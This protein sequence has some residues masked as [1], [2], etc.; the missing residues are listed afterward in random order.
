VDYFDLLAHLFEINYL[1]PI[2]DWCEENGV[3]AGGHLLLEHDPRRFMEGGCGHPM[4]SFRHFHIP[5]IDSIFRES[6]PYER[7]HHFPKYV[8]SVARQTGRPCSCMPFGAS[9][10]AVTPAIF[11]WTVD[12]QLVRGVQLFLPWGY[13]PNPDIHYQWSR[14]VFGHFGPLWKY[15]DIAYGYTARLSY[16]LSLGAPDCR[17]ALYFDMRSIWAGEPWRTRAIDA[18]EAIAKA[19]LESQHDFDF[20]DDDG[21][22]SATLEPGGGLRVGEMVYQTL[23]VPENEWMEPDARRTVECFRDA[24][25]SVRDGG[26]LDLP[27]LRTETAQPGLRVCKRLLDS[28]S[29]YFLVNE[30]NIPI[31]TVAAFDETTVPEILNPETGSMHLVAADHAERQLRIP[32]VLAPW[33]TRV[34]HFSME[35]ESGRASSKTLFATLDEWSA[36]TVEKTIIQGD[37]IL[38]VPCERQVAPELGDWCAVLGDDFTGTVRYTTRFE[39]V[40]APQA[41]RWQV[42][43]GKICHAGT[44]R[45]NGRT[46][47][48]KVWAPF[49][50][51]LPQ[52]YLEEEN[53]LEVEVS[54]TMSNL[55]TS[56]AYLDQID[57]L[58]SP[59]GAR[60]VRIL[61]GWEMESRPSGLFGPVRLFGITA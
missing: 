52:E 45:L 21:L 5:G 40:P 28:G 55:F 13:S 2:F 56:P 42:D 22:K 48:R 47:G 3:I 54:N 60:Y 41:V 14:P 16:L 7:S 15:M 33:E 36:C 49:V 27:L 51:D 8:S 19:L 59:E 57:R 12:H 44:V 58:Y 10:C 43:L 30:G 53:V 18:Q 23:I 50:F 17:I 4:R 37:R 34:F 35:R 32:L 31:E 11:K 24:G 1:K 46:L 6:H 39:L 29:I 20:V 9:S 26:R 61:E 38:T 25:G